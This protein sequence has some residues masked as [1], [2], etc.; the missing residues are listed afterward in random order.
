M[1]CRDMDAAISSHSGQS[2]LSPEAA[3][4]AAECDRC[5]GL[6][7]VLDT[8]ARI[9]APPVESVKRIQASLLGD[10]RPVRPLGSPVATLAGLLVGFAA[11]AVAGGFQ[12]HPYGWHV[13]SLA[14][15]VVIFGS[16]ALGMYTLASSLVRLMRPGSKYAVSPDL[17]PAVVGFVLAIVVYALF[18]PRADTP[19]VTRGL[20][21]LA[22]GV[23]YAVPGGLLSWWWLRRGAALSPKLVGAT[24]GGFAGLLGVTVLEIH[25]PNLNLY[26]ILVW[27]LAT[28]VV[29]VLG[30][31]AV[32]QISSLRSS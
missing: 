2:A 31:M 19:Y 3:A 14:Q 15:K 32:A 24:A 21:C 1:T 13:L 16:L 28:L 27:H 8:A 4:H 30:G 20:S 5:R 7:R 12:T 10:L 29:G 23:A 26:H 6:L 11:A 9:P 25:C 17:L 22:L 18:Q